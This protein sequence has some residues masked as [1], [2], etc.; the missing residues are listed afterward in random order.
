MSGGARAAD[1]WTALRGLRE[2]AAARNLATD[3]LESTA[4]KSTRHCEA[5]ARTETG[6]TLARPVFQ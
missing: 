4:A 3:C 1:V 2:L 5:H 6:R